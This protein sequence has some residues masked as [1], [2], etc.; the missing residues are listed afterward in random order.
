MKTFKFYKYRL[1]QLYT[2]PY[3][4]LTTA[5]PVWLW[6]HRNFIN[7]YKSREHRLAD[8]QKNL[9]TTLERDGIAVTHINK[10][11]PDSLFRS[12]KTAAAELISKNLSAHDKKIFL[13]EFLRRDFPHSASSPFMSFAM[14]PVLTEIANEYFQMSSRLKFIIGNVALPIDPKIVPEGSQRWH[15]DP[16]IHKICKVFLYLNDVDQATGPFMYIAGSQPGGRWA[17]ICPHKFFGQGSYYPKGGEVERLL[18]KHSAAP[19]VR[20]CIGSAG[21]LIICNT[22]GLHKG[23]YATKKERLMLTTFYLPPKL[24]SVKS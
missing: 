9:L 12:V 20:S 11:L 16:G 24:K 21:T 17:K 2:Y 15:R 10:L 7:A 13:L 1:W 6:R 8:P 14:N 19:D 18:E 5:K 23:G 4:A 22:M 3:Y